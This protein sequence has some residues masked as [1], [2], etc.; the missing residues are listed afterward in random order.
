MFD[1]LFKK[2]S[3]PLFLEEYEQACRAGWNSSSPLGSV[4]FVIFDTE[5]TGLDVK[6]AQLLSYGGIA[7]QNKEIVLSDSLEMIFQH[8]EDIEV[9][10][11]ASIHGILKSHSREIGLSLEKALERIIH[12]TGDSIL[13]GHHVNFD[14]QMLNKFLANYFPGAAIKNKMVDT[15]FLAR[16]LEHFNDSYIP[17][18][19]EYTL[20]ACAE[21]YNI[22]I[23]DRHTSAGDA[24]ITG[25]LLLKLLSKSQARGIRTC[26]DLVK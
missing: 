10:Q 11:T 4:R 9:N 1:F 5:T 13:V 6:N 14:V 20:D 18:S 25:Q 23:V 2:K 17:K 21:R 15:A 22:P 7:V 19:G 16:R 8:E 3:L 24:F 26:G 12:F